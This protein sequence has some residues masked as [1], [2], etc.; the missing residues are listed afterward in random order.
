MY[1]IL[2]KVTNSAQTIAERVVERV[3]EAIKAD[4]MHWAAFY[5]CERWAEP[6][7]FSH[8]YRRPG[9]GLVTKRFIT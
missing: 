4:V 9:C 2:N 7:S 8:V 6:F 3:D 5:V 1:D